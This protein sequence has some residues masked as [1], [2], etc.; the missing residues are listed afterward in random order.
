MVHNHGYLMA[1][2]THACTFKLEK[3]LHYVFLLPAISIVS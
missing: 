3:N 2:K 1:M